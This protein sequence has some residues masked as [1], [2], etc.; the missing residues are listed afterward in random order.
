LPR[1]GYISRNNTIYIQKLYK[2][3]NLLGTTE[4]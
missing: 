4:W 3:K 2:E 1:S